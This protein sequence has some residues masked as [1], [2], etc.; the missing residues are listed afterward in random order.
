M[1]NGD[2]GYD[3]SDSSM[4]SFDPLSKEERSI[5]S[6]RKIKR[7]IC[8]SRVDKINDQ[9]RNEYLRFLNAAM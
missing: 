1:Q 4:S 6:G 7:K 8:K 2:N 5:I 3:L 9:Q